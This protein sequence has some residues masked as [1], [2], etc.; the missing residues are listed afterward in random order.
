MTCARARRFR[1]RARRRGAW[2]WAGDTAT[3]RIYPTARLGRLLPGRAASNHGGRYGDVAGDGV[4]DEP[5]WEVGGRYGRSQRG[6]VAGGD[7]RARASRVEP[8]RAGGA[9][10]RAWRPA[11]R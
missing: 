4:A 7:G 9:L 10:T 11:P 2:G 8:D 3:A 1:D 6:R 5:V